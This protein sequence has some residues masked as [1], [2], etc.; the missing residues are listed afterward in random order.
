[1]AAPTRG[2]GKDE[3][4]SA[5]E[6][7]NAMPIVTIQITREGTTREQKALLRFW[8]IH[9]HRDHR[10][11]RGFLSMNS[12]LGLCDLGGLYSLAYC[13]FHVTVAV[14]SSVET[15]KDERANATRPCGSH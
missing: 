10:V 8:L 15:E 11:H 3:R 1:M 13:A 14:F 5:K 7:E 9:L 4:G 2:I 12:S 6:D